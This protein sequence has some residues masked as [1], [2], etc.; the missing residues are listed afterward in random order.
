M[1]E[2]RVLAWIHPKRGGDDYQV[3]LNI[4]AE[5]KKIAEKMVRKWLRKKSDIENDFRFTKV[6]K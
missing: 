3:E 6:K 1:K 5:N 4:T 2:Y